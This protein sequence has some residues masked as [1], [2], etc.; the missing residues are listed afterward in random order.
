MR[1]IDRC[2][3]LAAF[4]EFFEDGLALGKAE[5]QGAEPEVSVPMHLVPEVPW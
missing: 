5:A 2:V 4:F 3:R 1:R